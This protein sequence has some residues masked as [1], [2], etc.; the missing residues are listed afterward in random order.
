MLID[1]PECHLTAPLRAP[2]LVIGRAPESDLVIPAPIISHTAAHVRRETDGHYTLYQ[3]S[4]RNPMRFGEANI[5]QHTF[6]DDD[7]V[8]I[9]DKSV[10]SI[11]IL[12]YTTAVL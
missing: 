7:R 12:R 6:A 10:G 8:M 9:G 3:I 4:N 2:E 11:V 5:E 1:C